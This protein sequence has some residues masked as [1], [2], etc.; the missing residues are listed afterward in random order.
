[1]KQNIKYLFTNFLLV[2]TLCTF[3]T[4]CPPP[5]IN[6]KTATVAIF[7]TVDTDIKTTTPDFSTKL[8]V[9]K[10]SEITAFDILSALKE[11]ES[12]LYF[13]ILNTQYGPFIAGIAYD[14]DKNGIAPQWGEDPDN[15]ISIDPND[16]YFYGYNSGNYWAVLHGTN[17]ENAQFAEVGIG[18]LIIDNDDFLVLCAKKYIA[19]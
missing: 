19:P 8:T 3:L 4:S 11:K 14:I 12:H 13:N 16:K 10:E 17:I 15:P 18:E 5:V 9:N 2:L 7:F 1:M 6:S